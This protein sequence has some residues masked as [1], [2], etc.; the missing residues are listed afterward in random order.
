MAIYTGDNAMILCKAIKGE[1]DSGILVSDYKFQI[2]GILDSGIVADQKILKNHVGREYYKRLFQ[3]GLTS[4]IKDN[5]DA[6]FRPDT[7][8]GLF[9]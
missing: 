5:Y 4:Y 7:F 3:I 9:S 1:P 8:T 2:T 6:G